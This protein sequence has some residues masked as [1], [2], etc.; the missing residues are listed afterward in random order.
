[1]RVDAG[2]VEFGAPDSVAAAVARAAARIVQPVHLALDARL[3]ARARLRVAE[4]AAVAAAIVSRQQNVAA[5]LL[6]GGIDFADSR[7]FQQDATLTRRY[8]LDAHR[9]IVVRVTERGCVNGCAAMLQGAAAD[10]LAAFDDVTLALVVTAA[11][12]VFA[13]RH[14]QAGAALQHLRFVPLHASLLGRVFGER[15]ATPVHVLGGHAE[16]AAALRRNAHEALLALEIEDG[17]V[18]EVDVS[19]GTLC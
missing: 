3:G 4:A 1:M 18:V 8:R 10:G 2:L 15:E 5:L 6:L 17:D 16:R 19:L 7:R 12:T 13:G 14:R 9:F 11:S